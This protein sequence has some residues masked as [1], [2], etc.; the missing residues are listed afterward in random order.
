MRSIILKAL[1]SYL[2][3]ELVNLIH[4]DNNNDDDDEYNISSYVKCDPT[5][6]KEDPQLHFQCVQAKKTRKPCKD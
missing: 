1:C 6:S 2:F 5:L 4:D 3:L